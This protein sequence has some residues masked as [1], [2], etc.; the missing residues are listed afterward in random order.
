MVVFVA[1]IILIAMIIFI[2]MIILIAMIVAVI[3]AL[4]REFAV[5]GH[6]LSNTDTTKNGSGEHQ[7]DEW[8]EPLHLGAH[9]GVVVHSWIGVVRILGGCHS[10]SVPK[11]ATLIPTQP[12]SV[13]TLQ[14]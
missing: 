10:Q 8:A 2:A 12:R 5:V 13:T 9:S 6:R 3:F 4:L 11:D 1:M 7:S 14:L